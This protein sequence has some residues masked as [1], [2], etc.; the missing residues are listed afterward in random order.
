MSRVGSLGH[1]LYSGDISYD[2]VGNAKRWYAV[3]VVLMLVSI[4]AIVG[5]GLDLGIEFRGGAQLQVSTP[6]AD[7]DRARS[8]VEGLGLG[9]LRVV[10][11][12][13]SEVRVETE[14]ITDEQKTQARDALAEEFGVEPST[15]SAQVIGPSWGSDISAKALRGLLI[16]LVLVTLFMSLY[17]EWKMAL[18]GM[19]ALVHDLL[20][21]VGLYALIGFAVTPATVIG[22]LTILG[23]SLYDTVVVF[24]KV[25]E[26]TAGLQGSARQSYSQAANLAVNQ[27]LVRSI[28]T[29]VIALLPVGAILF[30]GAGLLRAETL[31]DLSLALF[32]GIAT[33][34][35]S[36]VF[37]ATPIVAQLK[38]REPA[39]QALARRA[40][41]RQ[42]GVAAGAP[43]ATGTAAERAARRA[44]RGT[45][46]ATALAVRDEQ[47]AAGA[48]DSEPV[49]SEPVGS[50][51]VGS[52]PVDFD[53]AVETAA[54]P[55]S[56]AKQPPAPRA[57][58]GGAAAARTQQRRPAS[59]GR[60]SGKKRR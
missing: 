13:D 60:P 7:V 29:S 58:G 31:K 6:E 9:E 23:Y 57:G 36:S 49:D 19:I 1:R 38:E 51:P 32:I 4:G 18:A 24:D 27:T 17:F 26:N 50:E 30:I 41:S 8:A 16:F 55:P 39:M 37:I 54:A 34:T 15:V 59:K 21:T 3:S 47:T 42:S 45:G 11:I 53:P 25:K 40:A 20:L 44:A 56:L 5:R 52:E 35:Y 48:A 43:A 33:G 28:N 2:F 10:K 46:G 22:L 12:G 14:E